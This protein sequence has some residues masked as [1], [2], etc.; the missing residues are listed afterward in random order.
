[1]I[2]D[3]Q[4]LISNQNLKS[5]EQISVMLKES[6]N[7]FTAIVGIPV[8]FFDT[9]NDIMWRSGEK[10]IICDS[11]EIYGNEK[12]MCRRNLES[13]T[14]IA[15]SFSEPYIF[16]CRA[17]LVKIAFTLIIQGENYG[18]F[19]A[20]PLVMGELKSS[21]LSTILN[22]NPMDND[23]YSKALLDL[24]NLRVYAPKEID[25]LALLLRSCILSCI[26][27]N[28]DYIV[29]NENYRQSQE[30]NESLQKS[31]QLSKSISYPYEM[32]NQLVKY[33]NNG[34]SLNSQQVFE[35]LM[36]QLSI[37]EAGE[38][39]PIKIAVI[40]ICSILSKTALDSSIISK[41]Q[42]DDYFDDIERIN[43]A[44]N[45]ADI[46]QFTSS[47]IESITKLYGHNVYSGDSLLVKEAISIVHN[48]YDQKLPLV[49]VAK[50]LHTHPS[51][52]STL[53]KKETGMKFVDFLNDYRVKKSKDLLIVTT[54]SMTD[55]AVR[56]GFDNQ[57]YFSKV[58]KNCVGVSPK[59]FRKDNR[60]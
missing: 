21:V 38:L 16:L 35:E 32:E 39:A 26:G 59:E 14:S 42:M 34:D 47:F 9:N 54:L 19:I 22:L 17:G 2:S 24:K 8:T 28:Q 46:T 4:N 3:T 23:S 30:I 15:S 7:S 52:L 60:G 58:F 55:I 11:F 51:Y 18:C 13:A 45:L 40:G 56:T 6:L 12:S 49:S 20:G 37:I 53:F 29:T 43:Q 48:K 57:S 31:K 44:D 36:K 10:N 41:S 27:T 25:N 50:Q 5:A 1:M 33:V